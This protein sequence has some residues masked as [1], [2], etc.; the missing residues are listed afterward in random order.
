MK[1]TYINPTLEVVEIE[2]KNQLLAGSDPVLGA[3]Y[4]SSTDGDPLGRELDDEFGFD[5]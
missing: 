4:N 3:E 5:E 1:K 2:I